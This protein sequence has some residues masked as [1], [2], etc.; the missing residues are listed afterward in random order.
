MPIKKRTDWSWKFDTG[1]PSKYKPEYCKMIVDYFDVEAYTEKQTMTSFNDKTGA[2]KE[3]TKPR[4][5]DFPTF[6]WFASSIDVNDD[7]LVEWATW[8][9]ENWLLKFPDFSAAYMKAKQLQKKILIINWMNWLYKEWFAK[10]VAVNCFPEMK[11]KSEVDTKHSGTIEM[12]DLSKLSEEELEQRRKL[13]LW[14][15]E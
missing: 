12:V 6:E 7:T 9:N 1:R 11:D 13:L 15:K 10:F 8:K 4:P 14:N 3:Y 5:T 2:E